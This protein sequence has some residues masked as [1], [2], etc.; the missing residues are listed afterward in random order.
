MSPFQ[1]LVEFWSDL[2]IPQKL[3]ISAQLP[4]YK[5]LP[6]LFRSHLELLLKWHL[7]KASKFM[8]HIGR[9]SQSVMLWCAWVSHGTAAHA[10]LRESFKRKHQ[11][12]SCSSLRSGTQ[13]YLKFSLG[14]TDPSY[15]EKGRT[16]R[17]RDTKAAR[18]IRRYVSVW[19]Q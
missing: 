10:S 17:S 5:N 1:H 8:L 14:D 15:S 7:H 4:L 13:S 6:C 18:T 12:F 2:A 11:S 19:R 3:G 9:N 16:G